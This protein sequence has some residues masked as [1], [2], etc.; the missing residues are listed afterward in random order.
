V[1][2]VV[3]GDVQGRP[4]AGVV[5]GVPGAAAGVP[6]ERPDADLGRWAGADVP[7]GPAPGLRGQRRPLLGSQRPG[8]CGKDGRREAAVRRL[9]AEA[10]RPFRKLFGSLKNVARRLLDSIRYVAW[11]ESWF[12]PA[13]AGKL[14]IELD[15]S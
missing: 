12:D 15:S 9:A 2:L 10:G 7:L 4:H 8:M 11:E 6:G 3:R 1:G 13:Q 5:A 14:R